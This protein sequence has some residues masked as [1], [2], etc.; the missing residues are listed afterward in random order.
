MSST[1]GHEATCETF[2]RQPR[3]VRVAIVGAGFSGLGLAIQLKRTGMNDFIVLER[4]AEIGGTWRDN[5]LPRLRLRRALAPLF[6]LLR[7]Q[8]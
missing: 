6:V 2:S 4:A 3:D 1:H 7:A 8:P 5:T